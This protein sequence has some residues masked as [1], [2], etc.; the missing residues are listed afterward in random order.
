MLPAFVF[1]MTPSM[2]RM[3]ANFFLWT[4]PKNRGLIQSRF[5]MC[6]KY[7][8]GQYLWKWIKKIAAMK[9]AKIVWEDEL[10]DPDT[11]HFI[12]SVDCT[13]L[14]TWEPSSHPFYN[15]D[16]KEMSHK[17]KHAAKKFEIALSLFSS[18][19]AW[20]SGPHSGGTHDL[21]VFCGGLKM[22]IMHG[23]LVIADRG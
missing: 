12:I 4:Y 21:I 6:K 1:A 3:M 14:R 23:K 9:A 17:H 13:D 5:G 7:C 18:Q 16:K 19:I 2:A 8:G 11:Q 20:I 22:M 15:I 10:D